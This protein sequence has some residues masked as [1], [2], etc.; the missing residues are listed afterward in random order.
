VKTLLFALAGAAVVAAAAGCF[1][2]TENVE[3]HGVKFQKARVQENGFAIGF[4]GGDAV[5][6]GR[7]C[8][9]GWVH[10]HPNGIPAGFTASRDIALSRFTIPAGTWVFQNT[11]GVVTV[12]AF[13]RDLEIQG[14]ECRGGFGGSE[15]TQTAFYPDG[16]LK[17][18]FAPKPVRI[19]GIPCGASAFQ[20]GIELYENG[21]LRSATLSEDI[22]LGGRLRSKGERIRLTTEGR[23]IGG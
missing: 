17:Q 19:D 18:F 20:P 4:I 14:H 3:L 6:A 1:D 8:R 22:A 23:V 15:G 2:W 21:R 10:L 5:I 9:K 16:A 13:P 11:D 7:P 12:C